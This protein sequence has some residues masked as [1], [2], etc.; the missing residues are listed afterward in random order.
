MSAIIK[1]EG[2]IQEQERWEYLHFAKRRG[3]T[4]PAAVEKVTFPDN[5]DTA[6]WELDLG[7]GVKGI[8]PASESGLDDQSL[9]L[10]FV[11]Q[12]V[13]V[14][15]KKLD[16]EN[17]IVAC[18]RREAVADAAERLFASLKSDMVI[19]VMVKA[20]FPRTDEKPDRLIVDAGGGILVEIP[21]G[22]ATQN[23]TAEMTKLFR[24]GQQAKAKVVQVDAQTGTIRLNMADLE[25]DPWSGQ[26]KRGDVV[27]GTVL[28]QNKGM[29]FV[30]VKPG[31][32]G[33]AS[34]PLRGYLHKGTHVAAM[35]TVFDP[36][37][38]KLHMQILGQRA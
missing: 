38:K 33:I 3:L 14:K 12:T 27:A 35:V 16:R 9:M 17:G 30:E 21:R 5:L 7:G 32:I 23:I 10:R 18:S 2:F 22:Q 36:E 13:Q 37:A 28:I 8:V 26:Y 25:A 20:V 1:P 34:A 11:G 29:V 15:V 24:P 6:V 31:L 19:D 4:V